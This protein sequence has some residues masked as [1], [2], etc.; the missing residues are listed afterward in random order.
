MSTPLPHPV[1]RYDNV[2][3]LQQICEIQ[4]PWGADGNVKTV[5]WSGVTEGLPVYFIEPQSKHK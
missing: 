1:H 5:V 4:V 3:E 2:S